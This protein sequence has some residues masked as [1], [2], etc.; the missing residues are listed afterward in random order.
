[1][2]GEKGDK[3]FIPIRIRE[4]KGV[5]VRFRTLTQT[6]TLK[7]KEYIYKRDAMLL[8]TIKL[9]RNMTIVITELLIEKQWRKTICFNYTINEQLNK[10]IVLKY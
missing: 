9:K 1:M 10:Q 4:G 8:K 5:T 6:K 3:P 7:N 2:R